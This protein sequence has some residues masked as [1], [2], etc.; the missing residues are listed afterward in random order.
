MYACAVGLINAKL[1]TDVWHDHML[2]SVEQLCQPRDI[3]SVCIKCMTD[4]SALLDSR[5][6]VTV[7][8]ALAAASIYAARPCCSPLL[9]AKHHAV[10]HQC[11]LAPAA[12]TH[13]AFLQLFKR[14]GEAIPA[15]APNRCT[16]RVVS[17]RT[18]FVCLRCQAGHQAIIG[19]DG[20]SIIQCGELAALHCYLCC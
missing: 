18:I 11:S 14:S 17:S 20:A 10:T 13:A 19:A 16:T 5:F 12:L 9:L 15:C 3:L 2:V 6:S 4:A 1:D 8:A 7:T